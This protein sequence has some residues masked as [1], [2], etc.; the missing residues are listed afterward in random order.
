MTD[1]W[2]NQE[3]PLKSY[4]CWKT[5]HMQGGE[6]GPVGPKEVTSPPK[7]AVPP[8][9]RHTRPTR[10]LNAGS[11]AVDEAPSPCAPPASP[12][13]R[14]LRAPRGL[15]GARTASRSQLRVVPTRGDAARECSIRG[16]MT[17]SPAAAPGGHTDP[18][19]PLLLTS[20]ED[21]A[22][23]EET[24]FLGP[25]SKHGTSPW[26]EG[27]EPR[28]HTE[29]WPRFPTRHSTAATGLSDTSSQSVWPWR[30]PARPSADAGA[31]ACCAPGPARPVGSGR[32]LCPFGIGIT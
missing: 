18:W 26:P 14:V 25:R 20:I 21:I 8:S 6:A 10:S 19:Q 11:R 9:W 5:V 22:L 30:I 29:K 17:P 15:L 32:S 4:V 12:G 27:S 3:F 2:K 23:R 7:A 16:S 28:C 1:F 13:Q 31:G 24:S